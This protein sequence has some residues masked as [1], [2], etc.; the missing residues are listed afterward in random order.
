MVRLKQMAIL[1]I[2]LLMHLFPAAQPANDDCSGAAVLNQNS[3]CSPT[4]GTTVDATESIPAITCQRLEGYADDDV[5]YVFTATTH[6][7]FI[8]VYPAAGFDAVVD[9]RSSPCNG[10]SIDCSDSKGPGG[11]EN[12]YTYGLLIG[13]TYYI[14]IYSYGYGAT[15]QGNFTVC[16]YGS[17][18]PPPANDNCSGSIGLVEKPFC[19]QYPGTTISATQSGEPVPCNGATGT[20]DDDVWYIFMPSTSNPTITVDASPMFDAVVELREVPCDGTTIFCA[21]EGGAGY[22][23]KL[24]AAGLTIGKNYLIRV[25]SF[26]S[27]PN[28]PEEFYICVH[29]TVCTTCPEFDY[30]ISPGPEWQVH[31]SSTGS[32]G[33]NTYQFFADSGTEYTFKTGCGDGASADFDTFLQVYGMTCDSLVS[34]DNS[35]ENGR[36]LI[37]WTSP[38]DGPA[39][40]QLRGA[41]GEAFGSYSLAYRI[42]GPV[43]V[44]GPSGDTDLSDLIRVYPNPALNTFMIEAEQAFLL[45]IEIFDHTGA[46]IDRLIQEPPVQAFAYDNRDLDPGLY[47][48][49][50]ETNKGR[51]HKKLEVIP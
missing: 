49:S 26:G 36:S 14:R 32:L 4:P 40:L 46:L 12:I 50:V 7:P 33:C 29:E 38:Y 21:D 39:Y 2:P 24:Y 15:T 16:V 25:Y 11:T 18:P 28:S 43:S 20:A 5:W 42:T 19:D 10:S 1:V 3:S 22:T 9:L 35:C 48:L 45:R 41:N 47:I 8:S 34:D 23:E 51:V 27:D 13:V 30:E 31:P 17:V 37:T 44:P 6:S